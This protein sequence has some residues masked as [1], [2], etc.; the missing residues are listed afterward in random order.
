MR[1]SSIFPI[2]TYIKHP[3]HYIYLL[4]LT[5]QAPF[6]SIPPSRANSFIFFNVFF[7]ILLFP[8]RF[9]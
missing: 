5:L 2:L 3:K 4:Q 7:K 6:S 1:V 8:N 9:D